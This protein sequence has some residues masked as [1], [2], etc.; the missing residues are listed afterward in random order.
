MLMWKRRT[1]FGLIFSCFC[2][3]IVTKDGWTALR[4]LA[5]LGHAE[6]VKLLVDAGANVDSKDKVCFSL[7]FLL[8]VM[9]CWYRVDFQ[10][11]ILKL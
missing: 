9:F 5:K 4:Y 7:F 8:S 11:F 3:L 10:C 2:S 6:A 1:G